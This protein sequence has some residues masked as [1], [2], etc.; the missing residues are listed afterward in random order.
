MCCSWDF[1]DDN[2]PFVGIERS[3]VFIFRS[4]GIN[5]FEFLGC[6]QSGFSFSEF[7][8]DGLGVE[9]DPTLVRSVDKAYFWEK[10]SKKASKELTLITVPP[11]SG[12]KIA[13]EVSHSSSKSIKLVS[14]REENL[15]SDSAKYLDST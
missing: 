15:C 5:C 3:I 10:N 7:N 8:S 13:V 4:N 6:N 14:Q 9:T 1:L 12:A 11:G 2:A